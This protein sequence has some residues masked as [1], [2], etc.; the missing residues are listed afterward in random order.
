MEEE[1][2]LQML[3]LNIKRT[4]RYSTHV[5]WRSTYLLF[6]FLKLS[7]INVQ[8]RIRVTSYEYVWRTLIKKKIK[9]FSNIRKF[10]M[11]QLQSFLWGGLFNI[12]GNAQI[13]S[14]KWGAVLSVHRTCRYE[15]GGHNSQRDVVYL[16]WP[17]ALSYMSP[18]GG[19]EGSCGDS[20][21]EYIC[22]HGA[23]K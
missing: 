23:P 1:S 3:I 10:R 19:E 4:S 14:H 9:F 18:N 7:Y 22:A 5:T 16:G 8:I 20:A 6:P 2:N 21:N 11:E 15:A 17:T 13:F 12:W